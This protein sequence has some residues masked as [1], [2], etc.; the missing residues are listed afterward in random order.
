M[1]PVEKL[2]SD[3]YRKLNAVN[4]GSS[5]HYNISDVMSFIHEAYEIWF[6]NKVFMADTNQRVRND[7]RV[8][9]VKKLELPCVE[10][11][12][13]C[14]KVT[15]PDNFYMLLNQVAKACNEECCG[16]IK[17]EIVINAVQA[18][19]LQPARRNPYRQAN[20]LWEQL[21]YDEAGDGMYVYHDRRMDVKTVCIDYYR[22]P[23]MPEA[24]ELAKCSKGYMDSSGNRITLNKDLEVDATFGNRQISDIAVAIASR[25]SGDYTDF[26]QQVQKILLIDTLHR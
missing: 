3:F 15:Y 6:E 14:C 17:K 19:D 13:D 9:E 1:V 12:C 23:I 24:G 7:L 20:F 25:D 4:S 16:D 22:K 21:I 10:V 8:F 18:D 2:V 5:F 11:D 26:Q